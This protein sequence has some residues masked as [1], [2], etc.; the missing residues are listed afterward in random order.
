M[1]AVEIFCVAR[2]CVRLADTRRAAHFFVQEVVTRLLL[3]NELTY[4][5][6]CM[7]EI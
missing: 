5:Y 3:D 7:L 2:R 4:F 1:G 6:L